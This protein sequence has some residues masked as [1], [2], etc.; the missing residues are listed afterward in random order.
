LGL[1]QRAHNAFWI[2]AGVL[3]IRSKSLRLA[4]ALS[5]QRKIAGVKNAAWIIDLAVA[6]QINRFHQKKLAWNMFI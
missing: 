1:V 3:D 6:D 4:R 5:A 2:A